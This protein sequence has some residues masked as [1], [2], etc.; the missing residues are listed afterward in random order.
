M[1]IL[2]EYEAKAL[3]KYGLLV[4][5]GDH[6]LKIGDIITASYISGWNDDEYQWSKV[7]IKVVS[8]QKVCG[9]GHP[10]YVVLQLVKKIE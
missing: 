10:D 1:T 2:D 6:H 7:Q 4:S 8:R 5:R 9:I 3:L